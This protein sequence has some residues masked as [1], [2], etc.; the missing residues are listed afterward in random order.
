MIFITQASM[1]GSGF[2]CMKELC[3]VI[4]LGAVVSAGATR[5]EASGAVSECLGVG[6]GVRRA[7]W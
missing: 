3:I 1:V 2:D 5:L 7:N 6:E 4:T